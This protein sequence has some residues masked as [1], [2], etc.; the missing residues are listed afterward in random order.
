MADGKSLPQ[1]GINQSIKENLIAELTQ[2]SK[3]TKEAIQQDRYE[4]F[5]KF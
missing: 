4:R 3:L 2:L 1:E 5:R